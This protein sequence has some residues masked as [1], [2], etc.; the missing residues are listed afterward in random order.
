MFSPDGDI[1]WKP[2]LYVCTFI[3]LT[4]WIVLQVS[5]AVLL[6]N[7][8]TVSMRMESAEK[9]KASKERKAA[10][11]F[12]NPLEP[13]VR[14]LAND[15]TD[16]ASLSQKLLSLF[17]ACDEAALTFFM[18]CIRCCIRD[19][20]AVFRAV[21]ECSKRTHWNPTSVADL[22]RLLSARQFLDSNGSGGS[23]GR[24]RS[25]APP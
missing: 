16:N 7:F 12:Q 18:C 8:V 6:D 13:L 10:S 4:V 23:G 11:Q 14:K 1:E 20:C 9:T 24:V 2:A 22:E 19:S 17:K 25:S 21:L 15:F 3:V 5:V